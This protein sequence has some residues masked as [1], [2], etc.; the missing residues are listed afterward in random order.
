M[1]FDLSRFAL[2]KPWLVAFGEQ[3][4]HTTTHSKWGQVWVCPVFFQRQSE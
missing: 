3:V 1:K 2:C 4:I